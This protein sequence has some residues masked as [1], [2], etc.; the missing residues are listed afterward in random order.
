M[1]YPFFSSLSLAG[2]FRRAQAH[3]GLDWSDAGL[4][5]V[6]AAAGRQTVQHHQLD[7]PLA[8]MPAGSAGAQQLAERLQQLWQQG[9]GLPRRVRAALPESMLQRRWLRLPAGVSASELEALVQAE[10]QRQAGADQPELPALDFQL[11]PGEAGATRQ[12]V[13]VVAADRQRLEQ[14]QQAARVAGLQLLSV[15]A[16]SHAAHRAAIHGLRQQPAALQLLL[17][18]AGSG[19]LLLQVLQQGRPWWQQR[20]PQQRAG[21]AGVWLDLV[22]A[23]LSALPD[24][25]W[26]LAA[27]AWV[28]GT[29]VDADA[30]HVLSSLQAQTG[31]AWRCLEPA[32][33][34]SPAWLTACGLAWQQEPTWTP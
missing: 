26:L 19:Q 2:R 16:A 20:L 17:L 18:H 32:A 33:G 25:G 15:D 29:D 8:A 27:E 14:L 22:P 34:L 31:R 23:L 24:P 9:D 5:L 7:W 1:R 12:E 11:L 10:W 28:A 13:L 4:R 21:T 30:E 6:Q 3:V